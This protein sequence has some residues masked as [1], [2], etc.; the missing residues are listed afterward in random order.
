VS[1]DARNGSRDNERD[2]RAKARAAAEALFKAKAGAG[3]HG[4]PDAGLTTSS[5]KEGAGRTPRVFATPQ[6][7]HVR[8]LLDQEHESIAPAPVPKSKRVEAKR[9]SAAVPASHHARIRTLTTYGMS[10]EQVAEHFGVEV[11]E[12]E[13][14]LAAKR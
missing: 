10:R 9:R 8:P 12:I 14:I 6:A 1:F 5:L 4:A 11:G 2:Q 7:P 3:D 13:R